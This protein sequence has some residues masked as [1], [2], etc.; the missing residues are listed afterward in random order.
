LDIVGLIKGAPVSDLLIFGAFCAAF[1]VGA[2][3]GAIRRLLGIA[4]MLFAFLLSANLR[5][6]VGNYLADNWRQ[7]PAGY[8]KLLAFGL[9]FGVLWIGLSLLI[10][11]FYKRTDIYAARPVVQGFLL[12]CVALVIFGSYTLPAPFP[13]EVIFVRQI[14]DVLLN[15]SHIAAALRD[16]ALPVMIHSS[17][18]LLPNDI[19]AMFP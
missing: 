3:Q 2:M 15:Q 7:F 19:V 1:V 5:D 16:G 14:Q 4:S 6:P 17:G 9:L 12:L 11:G 8:T 10:Q 13:G 18:F